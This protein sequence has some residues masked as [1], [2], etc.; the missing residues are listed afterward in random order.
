MHQP[1]KMEQGPVGPLE[2]HRYGGRLG[3]A[4]DAPHRGAPARV[5]QRRLPKS[6]ARHLASR[7]HRQQPAALGPAN[8]LL[9]PGNVAPRGAV[10]AERVHGNNMLAHLGNQRQQM[11]GHDLHVGPHPPERMQQHNPL[12]GPEGMVRHHHRRPS[13]RNVGQIRVR[14]LGPDIQQPQHVLKKIRPVAPANLRIQRIQCGQ[15]EQMLQRTLHQPLERTLKRKIQ[16][17]RRLQNLSLRHAITPNVKRNKPLKPYSTTPTPPPMPTPRSPGCI[18]M[19]RRRRGRGGARG[20]ER[21]GLRRLKGMI[22]LRIPIWV[23]DA[24][25]GCLPYQYNRGPLC[26]FAHQGLA[27][28]PWC[29]LRENAKRPPGI[30]VKEGRLFMRCVPI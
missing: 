17:E 27:S 20:K 14:D 7:K 18:C 26:V 23:H 29:V 6:Q 28:S 8:R 25:T 19:T 3:D 1:Q 9:E 30:W 2:M 22:P 12:D 5:R 24:L 21:Q 11:V 10:L 4:D 15:P 13:G 16:T